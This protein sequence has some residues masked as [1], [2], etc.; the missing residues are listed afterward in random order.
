[1]P[2]TSLPPG[3]YPTEAMPSGPSSQPQFMQVA[4]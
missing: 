2:L 4:V 3:K 1:M